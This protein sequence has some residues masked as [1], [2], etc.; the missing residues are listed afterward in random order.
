MIKPVHVAPAP[1]THSWSSVKRPPQG[2]L[3]V[4]KCDFA[5]NNTQIAFL[6]WLCTL[7]QASGN[8]LTEYAARI[9]L[10]PFEI[11]SLENLGWFQLLCRNSGSADNYLDVFHFWTAE[12]QGFDALLTLEKDP[13]G[14]PCTSGEGK[15]NRDKC[16]CAAA[17]G[18]SCCIGHPCCIGHLR[19]R[20][21][22]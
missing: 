22:L 14:C 1:R 18:P 20:S 19:A 6:E 13:T 10:S 8:V 21:V 17:F 16:R 7:D 5:R 3:A 15:P 2:S 9:G 11:D 12:R 4:H